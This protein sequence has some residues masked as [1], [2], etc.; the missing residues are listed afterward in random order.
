MQRF[1]KIADCFQACYTARVR[2]SGLGL[3]R[4][5]HRLHHMALKIAGLVPSSSEEMVRSEQFSVVKLWLQDLFDNA[6]GEIP[7]APFPQSPRGENGAIS[8]DHD[9]ATVAGNTT[10]PGEQ[11]LGNSIETETEGPHSTM[12]AQDAALSSIGI[13]NNH[14]PEPIGNVLAALD[15]PPAHES[16][17]GHRIRD[18]PSETDSE[19]P[20][21]A[22][23]KMRHRKKIEAEKRQRECSMLSGA[24]L[25]M[26]DE[27]PDD[28][29]LYDTDGFVAT[30]EEDEMSGRLGDRNYRPSTKTQSAAAGLRKGTTH[31]VDPL[32]KDLDEDQGSLVH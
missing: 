10:S 9:M 6:T 28:T 24:G 30:D 13:S 23:Q 21:T 17:G 8:G 22:V 5:E 29:P 31:D 26:S 14:D 16:T 11:A 2:I 25:Q 20:R 3:S 12:P 4:N 1:P 32:G 7:H 27:D 18:T 19:P 15:Q